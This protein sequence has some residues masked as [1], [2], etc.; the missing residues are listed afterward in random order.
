M[1][2]PGG[3]VATL[4]KASVN[5]STA[6]DTFF[7]YTSLL[8]TADGQVPFT[9]DVSTNHYLV[10]PSATTS[11]TTNSPF[12]GGAGSGYFNGTAYL[13]A[14]TGSA[15]TIL[16]SANFTIEAWVYVIAQAPVSAYVM[17]TTQAAT[18]AWA[19]VITAGG[20]VGV[21]APVYTAVP[22]TIRTLD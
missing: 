20:Q 6:V 15:P 13:T 10:V 16:T 3:L 7:N 2:S 5:V 9:A 21:N 19:I 22:L 1:I 8:L 11:T 4:F 17:S 14:P 12:V 18:N